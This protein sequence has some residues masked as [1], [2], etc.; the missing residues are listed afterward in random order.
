[1]RWRIRKRKDATLIRNTDPDYVEF[2]EKLEAQVIK[3]FSGQDIR[4]S[5]QF[6]I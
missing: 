2:R 5:Y 4:L 6:E 1:M 3:Q